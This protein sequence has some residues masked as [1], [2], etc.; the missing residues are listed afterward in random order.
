MILQALLDFESITV[1]HNPDKQIQNVSSPEQCNKGIHAP[2]VIT[3]RWGTEVT[4][5]T[6][7]YLILKGSQGGLLF[8]SLQAR[9]KLSI[10]QHINKNFA[11]KLL[12]RLA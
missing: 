7:S 11:I 1:M 3:T 4:D 6:R 12:L 10:L 2:C 9:L 5:P 8:C